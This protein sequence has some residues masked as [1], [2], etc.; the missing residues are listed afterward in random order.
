MGVV[1]TLGNTPDELFSAVLHKQ[2][3]NQ[4]NEQF[5]A[6]GLR[7]HHCA[8]VHRP[9]IQQALQNDEQSLP[10]IV[11]MA[12]A[13][14]RSALKDAGLPSVLGEALLAAGCSIGSPQAIE[15]QN[16]QWR[17]K[18]LTN[19]GT[20]RDYAQGSLIAQT[21][22]HLGAKGPVFC[23]TTTCAAGNYAIGVGLD[24]LY[25]NPQLPFALVGGVEE[26]SLVPFTAFHQLRA[27]ADVC[28][29]FDKNRA[30]LLFGEGAAF[31]VLENLEH[32]QQRGVRWYGH[33]RSVGY[34]N[35]AHHLVAPDPDGAGAEKAMRR[36]LIE[37]ELQPTQIDY[38][39]AH[40]TG[41]PL[42]DLAE[43]KAIARVFATKQPLL[44]STKGATGHAMAAASALEAV[45][46][47][48]ALEQNKVPPTT[49]FETIDP[50][51]PTTVLRE[52]HN[53]PVNVAMSNGFG[54]GG[55]NA[56]LIVSKQ[57]A[58]KKPR[59]SQRVFVTG[60]AALVG[61]TL[62]FADVWRH[63]QSHTP[64]APPVP[65]GKNF[66]DLL[67]SKGLRHVER[68]ALLFASALEH[69][70]KNWPTCS[71]HDAGAVVGSAYPAL[72]GVVS[73]FQEFQTRGPTGINPM[74]VPFATAN[75]APSWWLMRRG[76]TGF[77]GS[78]GSGDCAGIDAIALAAQQIR[79]GRATD[80]VAGGVEAYT[81]ELWATLGH[82]SST[83]RPLAEAAAVVTLAQTANDPWAE[84]VKFDQRFFSSPS[85]NPWR[86]WID[87]H[88]NAYSPDLTIM[89]YGENV[90]RNA[91]SL[92]ESFGHTLAASGALGV[93]LAA[94]LI[95]CGAH[96]RILVVCLSAEGFCTIAQL[97]AA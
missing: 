96:K 28:R 86:S 9:R 10:W 22:S 91:V 75:C 34:S 39:N 52:A 4:K 42:N 38:I 93:L 78:L 64:P 47:L 76:I 85:N 33:V 69:D 57:P 73:L 41:T 95:H 77:S 67:G 62:G 27:L 94:K 61:D 66:G 32:A 51:I 20:L 18:D 11:Q 90:V 60:G 26:L 58:S 2:S 55:N 45:I 92:T 8:N 3:G 68:G 83:P 80:M 35:D 37:A 87:I 15:K 31:L 71:P 88:Q 81:P 89:T 82:L 54:F 13:A 70:L 12:I 17:D 48:K 49:G 97:G 16:A 6:A 7:H 79:K 53:T 84:I 24:A 21:A 56:V 36:A 1:S 59:T 50:N 30:G 46:T 44:S 25:E 14:A 23:L 19:P 29:P 43:A 40:G 63:F 74:L 72:T 65:F 5:A